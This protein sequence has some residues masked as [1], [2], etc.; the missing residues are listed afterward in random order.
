MSRPVWDPMTFR[1]PKFT[2]PPRSV[3]FCRP[4]CSASVRSAAAAS[5]PNLGKPPWAA[6]YRS[7]RLG[8]WSPRGTRWVPR[9]S[10]RFT[11]SSTSCAATA[12]HA[13]FL[14]H[15]GHWPR[16]AVAST[17][18]K[19]RL[20]PSPSSVPDNPSALSKGSTM[21]YQTLNIRREDNILYVDFNNPPVNLMNVAMVGELFD[22][23][24]SLAFDPQTAVVV[25]G[26]ANPE[27]F[28]AHFDLGDLVKGISGDPAVPQSQYDDINAVQALTTTW[29]T[30]PQVT[31]GMV[32]GICRG[33]GLGFLLA[34]TMRFATPQ[35]R[36]CFPEASGGILPGGGGTTRLA[37]QIGPARAAE[38]I[39]SSR[40]FTGDE[41]AA[42]G[43]VNRAIPRDEI[44]GHVDTLARGIAGR[45]PGAVASIN[46][47]I[48][49]VYDS[50]VDAQFAG[51]AS[52]N[53]GLRTLSTAPGV[54]EALQH[55][56]GLQDLDHERDL[57]A[58]IAP[59]H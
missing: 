11:S 8:D 13:R 56:S 24:G 51:F 58:T 28:I 35:S 54:K 22:L 27:F 17:A 53:N 43:V 18:G 21:T 20:Q 38:V 25:F 12:E 41:A 19:R 29:Q 32:D 37:L 33:E 6:G 55:L 44:A 1:W 9:A 39:L 26:S 36:F 15:E 46:Q 59:P 31:I 14:T 2:T 52:E 5:W 42:Y 23:A 47:V 48:K 3:N 34:P 16:R 30:L 49:S 4:R 10:R 57:P 50:M 40:D 7:T 45:S